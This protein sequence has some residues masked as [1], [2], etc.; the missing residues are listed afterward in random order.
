V[1]KTKNIEEYSWYIT[2]KGTLPDY[3][4]PDEPKTEMVVDEDDEFTGRDM[5][6]DPEDTGPKGPH[7]C[8]PYMD[9]NCKAT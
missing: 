2:P 6:I 4:I 9:H 5:T 1:F 8:N 7:N 3:L